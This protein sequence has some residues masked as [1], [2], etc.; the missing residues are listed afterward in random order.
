MNI[1]DDTYQLVPRKDGIEV[2][3]IA[4]SKKVYFLKEGFD[5]SAYTV[6][7]VLTIGCVTLNTESV[8]YTDMVAAVN[9]VMSTDVQA[10]KTAYNDF[11]SL[12]PDKAPEIA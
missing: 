3:E 6:G 4:T 8:D 1:L 11:V 2:I 9:G 7:N 5:F 12:L 10:L